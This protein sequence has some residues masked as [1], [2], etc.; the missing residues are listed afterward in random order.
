VTPG[1]IDT[2]SHIGVYSSPSVSSNSDGNE[3]TG[4]NTAEARAA[5]GYWPQ[6]PQITLR[7][8]ILC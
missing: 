3:A 4:P 6:D 7:R 8:Q 1:I 5:Y 2:H